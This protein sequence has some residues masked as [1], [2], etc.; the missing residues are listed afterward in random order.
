MTYTETRNVR[1]T[2]ILVAVIS[3][4]RKYFDSNQINHNFMTESKKCNF[5]T[6]C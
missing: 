2:P 6:E 3:S 5:V 4:S 1:T